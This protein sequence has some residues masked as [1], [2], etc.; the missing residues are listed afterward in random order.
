VGQG[1]GHMPPWQ[2]LSQNVDW[3]RLNVD[4]RQRRWCRG[5]WDDWVREIDQALEKE[6]NYGRAARIWSP[7]YRRR[8]LPVAVHGG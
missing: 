7:E 6:P 4:D 8:P 2:R 3:A 1:P 5:S